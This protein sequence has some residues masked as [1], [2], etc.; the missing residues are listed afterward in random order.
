MTFIIIELVSILVS[1]RAE[2]RLRVREFLAALKTHWWHS[3]VWSG[4]CLFD[5]FPIS[6]LNYI[7]MSR[8]CFRLGEN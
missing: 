3:A 7:V 1:G 6:I 2:A 4:C 5:T 8:H